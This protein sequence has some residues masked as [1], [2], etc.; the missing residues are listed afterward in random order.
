MDCA[1]SPDG[2][3]IVRTRG[4]R[5]AVD[6]EVL[7]D[8]LIRIRQESGLLR[9]PWVLVEDFSF[10]ADSDLLTRKAYLQ[11]FRH[12]DHLRGVV[13][14]GAHGEMNIAVRL[15]I[16]FYR[17]NFDVE[18]HNSV[19]AAFVQGLQWLG[20][21]IPAPFSSAILS[22]NTDDE[23]K[24][25]HRIEDLVEVLSE[26]Q[27]GKPGIT[28]LSFVNEK[29][30][31]KPVAET[32]AM[33][34]RDLDHLIEKRNL[35]VRELQDRNRANLELMEKTQKALQESRRLREQVAQECML[36]LRLTRSII[37]NQDETIFVLGE[38][39]ES[40]SRETANHIRRVS[41][42]SHLL[43]KH[44]GL[45]EWE[46]FYLLR[47]SPLHDAGK[48]AIPDAILNKPGKLTTEEFEI[49]KTHA[50]KGWELL[51][52][53]KRNILANSAI[54]ALQHHEKWNGKGYPYGL[55][56]EQIHIYGRIT[57][58]ADVFDALGSDRCYKKAWPLDKTLDLI[59]SERGE[60]FDPR[61][62]DIFFDHLP[63][64]ERVRER[65]PD[66]SN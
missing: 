4:E 50:I 26:V 37:E 14:C 21:E 48:V 61:L 45:A 47:G 32:M 55:S 9:K 64:F 53:S 56:G 38:I 6:I 65:F 23:R 57:A 16:T 2:L 18:V 24:E 28:T 29:S 20:V 3:V 46:S 60:H 11:L 41:E 27:W 39:I 33:V 12:Q 5:T 49:M 30:P 8:L 42:Y 36:N 54:I 35:R 25:I 51:K 58:L 10:V 40:R 43:S 44:S 15:G 13:Y 66:A 19:E 34:K 63:D 7:S 22:T 52:G 1:T 62:V 17:N 59:R 31:W